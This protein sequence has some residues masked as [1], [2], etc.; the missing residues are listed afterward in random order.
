[1]LESKFDNIQSA[2]AITGEISRDDLD[3]LI[4]YIFQLEEG[5]KEKKQELADREESSK[6]QHKT[7]LESATALDTI[8]RQIDWAI[9]AGGVNIPE[10][11]IRDADEKIRTLHKIAAIK[12][13]HSAC[14]HLGLRASKEWVENRMRQQGIL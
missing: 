2:V 5:Y 4:A 3:W 8:K 13:I 14:P 1:M 11:V 9:S 10:H 6:F 12:I 7:L